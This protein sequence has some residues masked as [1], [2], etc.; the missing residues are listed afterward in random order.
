MTRKR[1]RIIIGDEVYEVEAEIEDVRGQIL[2][3]KR[4]LEEPLEEPTISLSKDYIVSPIP[5]RILELKVKR[6]DHVRVGDVVAVLESMKAKVEL[7]AEVEGVVDE[8]YVSEG[9]TVNQGQKIAK[10]RRC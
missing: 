4:V 6:G 9:M 5:G 7:K 10:L 8:V 3:V 2:R 1:L